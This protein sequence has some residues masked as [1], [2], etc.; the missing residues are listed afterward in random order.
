MQYI[1]RFIPLALNRAISIMQDNT[2]YVAP[3]PKQGTSYHMSHNKNVWYQAFKLARD[4]HG[5]TEFHVHA[6]GQAFEVTDRQGRHHTVPLRLWKDTVHQNIN[7]IHTKISE[8][9]SAPREPSMRYLFETFDHHQIIDN[10]GASTSSV[11]SI[12]SNADYLEKFTEPLKAFV[13]RRS[14]HRRHVYLKQLEDLQCQILT[15]F[16]IASGIPPR[17][18]QLPSTSLHSYF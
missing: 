10:F 12:P 5:T 3:G 6:G 9:L 7:G 15:I 17:A 13:L 4:E 16:A 2:V 8:L 18:F 14:A 11:F 1:H